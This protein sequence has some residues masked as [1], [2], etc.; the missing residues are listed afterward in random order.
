M[1]GFWFGSLDGGGVR[2]VG[3]LEAAPIC[4]TAERST[5]SPFTSSVGPLVPL[6]TP[7]TV[8][9][10]TFPLV[11]LPVTAWPMRPAASLIS[12]DEDT[13][14]SCSTWE[15]SAIWFMKSAELVGSR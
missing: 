6:V 14:W 1:D 4:W 11:S 2:D 12:D 13:V 5:E 7:V 15:S 3:Q 9:L 8:P 10:T